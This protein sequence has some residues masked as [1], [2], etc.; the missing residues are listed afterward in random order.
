MLWGKALVFGAVM[1]V[2]SLPAVLIVFFAGQ[3]ILTGRHI[4]HI[5]FSHPGVVT[6]PVRGGST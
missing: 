1:F 6:R 2:I 3:A 5:A 4:L